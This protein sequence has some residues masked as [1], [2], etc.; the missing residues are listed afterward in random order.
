MA[1]VTTLPRLAAVGQRG[2]E[3]EA[4]PGVPS[5]LTLMTMGWPLATAPVSCAMPSSDQRVNWFSHA[6]TGWPQVLPLM[7]IPPTLALSPGVASA[8]SICW[9][10]G[11]DASAE[12][13]VGEPGPDSMG[14]VRSGHML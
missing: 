5:C 3:P 6:V 14:S 1:F 8:F 13:A 2:S 12:W 4:G 11:V 7:S 9:Y 10:P